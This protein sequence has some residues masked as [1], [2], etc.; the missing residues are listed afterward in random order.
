MSFRSLAI[1][2]HGWIQ[3]SLTGWL[4]ITLYSKLNTQFNKPDDVQEH[5]ALTSSSSKNTFFPSVTSMLSKTLHRLTSFQRNT[6]FWLLFNLTEMTTHVCAETSLLMMLLDL[7]IANYRQIFFYP[8]RNAEHITQ[9][10]SNLHTKSKYDECK[11]QI[12]NV[13]II[14]CTQF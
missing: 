7:V 14:T 4:H 3:K 13:S 9:T 5:Y 10:N 6:S 11:L 12:E 8:N 1:K 2:S